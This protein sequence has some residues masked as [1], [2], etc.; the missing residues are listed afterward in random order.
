MYLVACGSQFADGATQSAVVVFFSV[1][2]VVT[3]AVS[4]TIVAVVIVPALP[5][6]HR[7]GLRVERGG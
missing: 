6:R 2:A 3:A 1:R 7:D 4:V 5:T